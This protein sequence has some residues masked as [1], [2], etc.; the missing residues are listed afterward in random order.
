MLAFDLCYSGSLKDA[1]RVLAP[2]TQFRKPIMARLGPAQYVQ[3]QRNSDEA[4][5]AGRGYYERSG[6]IRKIEPDLIEAVVSRMEAPH[7]EPGSII[8]VHHGGAISRVKRDA[9]AFWH[10]DARHTVLVDVDWDDPTDHAAR[11]ANI[12][13]ARDT[14]HMVEPFTDGFYVNTLAADDAH[15]RIRSTYGANYPKLVALKD[16]YDSTNLFRMNANVPP[17]QVKAT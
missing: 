8:F 14:W 6:F 16:K 17:S 10:R 11:D 3:L 9:T 7:A 1:E 2:L 4:D 13:W 5:A 12:A 15:S